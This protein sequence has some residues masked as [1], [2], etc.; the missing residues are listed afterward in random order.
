MEE[1]IS[2]GRD[3]V[4]H[5]PNS[6]SLLESRACVV[7]RISIAWYRLEPIILEQA[8]NILYKIL[9]YLYV[10]FSVAARQTSLQLPLRFC[11]STW[12]R[13]IPWMPPCLDIMQQ[14]SPHH[15]FIHIMIYHKAISTA[16]GYMMRHIGCDWCL[17]LCCLVSNMLT[18][19][20]V[21]GTLAI[22]I[23]IHCECAPCKRWQHR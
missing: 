18:P 23:S 15:E 13:S 22:G 3:G 5:H 11:Y 2:E 9:V 12:Y 14:H 8:H 21:Y 17:H 7:G 6:R 1:C 20:G 4:E 19:P 10:L 16:T